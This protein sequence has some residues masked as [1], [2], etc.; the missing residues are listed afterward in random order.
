MRQGEIVGI[1]T[2]G[3]SRNMGLTIPA[4][5]INRVV[6]Q[7]LTKGHIARGYLGVGL[8]PVRLPDTLK[9]ALSTT[10]ETG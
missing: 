10:S 9:T 8:Q 5:T 3:L 7:L 1:N 6:E 2:S 4:T